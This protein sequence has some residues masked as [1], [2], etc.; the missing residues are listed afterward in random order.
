MWENVREGATEKNVS[1]QPENEKGISKLFQLQVSA[2]SI[3]VDV[4]ATLCIGGVC[5]RM[6]M[7]LCVCIMATG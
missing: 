6:C 3:P 7:C 2:L 5:G 1:S 4:C